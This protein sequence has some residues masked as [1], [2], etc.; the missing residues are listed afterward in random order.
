MAKPLELRIHHFFDIIRDIGLGKELKPHPYGHSLHQIAALIRQEP[1]VKIKIVKNCDAICIGCSKMKE[2][3][4]IDTVSHRSDFSSKEMF[5]DYLDEKILRVCDLAE[6]DILTP[7]DVLGKS[8][9]YLDHIF[10]IYEG[11]DP[12]DTEQRKMSVEEGIRLYKE[13]FRL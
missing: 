10:Q 12:Q 9:L 4:C 13:K 7:E 11:N 1:H 3:S 8:S 5:N 2:E 6:G